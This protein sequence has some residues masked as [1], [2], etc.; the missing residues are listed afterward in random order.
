MVSGSDCFKHTLPVGG[1]L[2]PAQAFCKALGIIFAPPNFST[3]QQGKP[4]QSCSTSPSAFPAATAP[5]SRR[6][7][8]P[9][10]RRSSVGAV[11]HKDL[12]ITPS[13]PGEIETV[14]SEAIYSGTMEVKDSFHLP[15][16]KPGIT[17][18]EAVFSEAN[19]PLMLKEIFFCVP[20][21]HSNTTDFVHSALSKPGLTHSMSVIPESTN[22][23]TAN[24]GYVEFKI[25]RL[26]SPRPHFLPLSIIKTFFML[27]L[28]RG[29]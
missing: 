19:F 29:L 6:K 21:G 10:H 16:S 7:K 4:C 27:H 24:S 5:S 20:P 9:C 25:V 18:S 8:L 28:S 12:C 17:I 23:M 1:Q 26:F 11:S 15:Q 3:P 22:T 2:M 13:K 14:Y